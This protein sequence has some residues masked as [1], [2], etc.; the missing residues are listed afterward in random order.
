MFNWRK[1]L[2]GAVVV[3]V[4]AFVAIQLV[5][6]PAR[7]NPPVQAHIQWDS[8]E[9]EQLVKDTCYDCHS[10]ETVWPWYSYIAPVSWLVAQDVEEG[11]EKLNFSEQSANDIESEELIEEVE[12]GGMPLPN[13]IV[14]H[15]N[16]KLTDKQKAHLIAGFE[17]SI[18]GSE[19]GESRDEAGE[20]RES[21]ENES[22]EN[23][24]S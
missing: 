17:A 8:L 19:E 2:L 1:I 22:A 21:G 9:T 3:G 5:P 4:V 24:A 20:G 15:P 11:R 13:Y 12:E 7:A 6:V 14:M 23:E 16:A 18:F 10:N